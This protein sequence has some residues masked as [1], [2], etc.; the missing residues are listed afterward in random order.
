MNSALHHFARCLLIVCLA[1]YATF[2]MAQGN[3]AGPG[4][5]MV[6]CADGVARTVRINADGQPVEPDQDC[7]ECLSCCHLMA[8]TAQHAPRVVATVTYTATQRNTAYSTPPIFPKRQILPVPRAPPFRAMAK[9]GY[10]CPAPCKELSFSYEKS[11]DGRP[12]RKDA[13]A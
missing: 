8:A 12:M 7:D 9:L 1:V 6:I 11:C 13:T 5:L 10:S 3:V 2:G 4:F